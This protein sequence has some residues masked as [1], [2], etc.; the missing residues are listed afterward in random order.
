M[1]DDSYV[2]GV[3]TLCYDTGRQLIKY[4]INTTNAT[5][6][7]PPAGAP[8]LHAAQLDAQ[9][10]TECA[11]CTLGPSRAF[12]VLEATVSLFPV[13]SFP[14]LSSSHSSQPR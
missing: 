11:D 4:Y 5:S 12:N 1:T 6:V 10:S 14:P 13:F 3:M 9:R 8:L 2:T 7:S